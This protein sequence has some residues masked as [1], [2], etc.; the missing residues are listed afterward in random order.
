MPRG[1]T[2][3]HRGAPWLMLGARSTGAAGVGISGKTYAYTRQTKGL[4][5]GSYTISPTLADGTAHTITIQLN[6]EG[7]AELGHAAGLAEEVVQLLAL[8]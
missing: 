3:N 2:A 5:A 7:M 6:D 1:P 8:C 4:A